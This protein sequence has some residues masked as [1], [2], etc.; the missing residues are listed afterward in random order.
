MCVR[1]RARLRSSNII[2][3]RVRFKILFRVG[4]GKRY[5]HATNIVVV[6]VIVVVSTNA[7]SRTEHERVG[8]F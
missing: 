5:L 7:T 3:E 2:P 1:V 8:F 6:V 4:F